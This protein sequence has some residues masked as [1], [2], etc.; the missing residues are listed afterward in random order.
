MG[1]LFF[2]SVER[3]HV[4]KRIDR[5]V[6]GT[7]HFS[8]EIVEHARSR[9]AA[10]LYCSLQRTTTRVKRSD[11]TFHAEQFFF[12]DRDQTRVKCVVTFPR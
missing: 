1:K 12:F 11:V 10:R 7:P 8:R 6:E 2:R 4:L 3:S 5:S 9:A